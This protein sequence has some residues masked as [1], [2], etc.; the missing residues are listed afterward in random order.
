MIKLLRL[1]KIFLILL[2][3]GF[4]RNIK[5]RGQ[6]ICYALESLGPI[7]IKFGQLLSTR[8]DLIPEDIAKSLEKLQDNVTPFKTDVAIKIVE[9]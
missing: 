4:K 3:L 9:R 7:Y 2:P 8:G 1:L 6:A 5:N